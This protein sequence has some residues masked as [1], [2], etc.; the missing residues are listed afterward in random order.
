MLL[1]K[2]E[3]SHLKQCLNSEL[4]GWGTADLVGNI[5]LVSKIKN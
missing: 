5:K 3:L 1:L 2:I 4:S